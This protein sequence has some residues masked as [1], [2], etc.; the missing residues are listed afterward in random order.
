MKNMVNE[1]EE[2]KEEG[3]KYRYYETINE[4]ILTCS[5]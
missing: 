3:E 1:K 5:C 4:I 2:K